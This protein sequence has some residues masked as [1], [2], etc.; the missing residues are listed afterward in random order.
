MR[1]PKLLVL[2]RHAQS[3]MNV[4]RPGVFLDNVSAAQVKGM[5]D[6]RVPL[7]EKGRAQAKSTGPYLKKV[8]GLF[9]AVYTS[10]YQRTKETLDGILEAYSPGEKSRMHIAHHHLLR[11]RERGYTFNMSQEEIE[12]A[13]PWHQSSYESSDYFYF[14]SPG[15]TSQADLVTQ[16]MMFQ[17]LELQQ[18]NNK[19]VMLVTHGGNIRGFRHNLEGW[20]PEQL[21][22]SMVKEKSSRNCGITV[23]RKI[24]GVLK[25][26][27]YD[28]I[29]W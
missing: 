10:P 19:K 14:R 17:H 8:F 2:V 1:V 27:S 23:Y 7:T 3:V 15:G 12:T 6:H 29:S 18:W 26:E 24:K 11:E 22:E 21:V 5:G 25:L 9:D 28:T 13:F 20:T 4:V 16:L